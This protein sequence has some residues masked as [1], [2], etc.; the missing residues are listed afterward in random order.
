MTRRREGG[1]GEVHP[2]EARHDIVVAGAH[3]DDN[4][5]AVEQFEVRGIKKEIEKLLPQQ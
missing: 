2:A 3:A 5:K 4:P 1:Q